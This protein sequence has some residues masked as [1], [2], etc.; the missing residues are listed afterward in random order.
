MLEKSPVN[1]PY[2]MCRAVNY[3]KTLRQQSIHISI[4]QETQSAWQNSWSICELVWKVLSHISR[5]RCFL[6]CLTRILCRIKWMHLQ[7]K[8]APS[9]GK[10]PQIVLPWAVP[11]NCLCLPNFVVPRETSFKPIIKR[12]TLPLKM[13]FAPNLKTGLRACVKENE[14]WRASRDPCLSWTWSSL[15][16]ASDF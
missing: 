16:Q 3:R 13:S 15:R 4:V 7:Y 10:V 14:K 11:P 1:S 8:F 6:S 5:K 12:N 2:A 9:S